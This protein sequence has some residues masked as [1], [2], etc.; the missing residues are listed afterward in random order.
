[1]SSR[2]ET[3]ILSC[4]MPLIVETMPSVRSAGFCWLLP[5]GSAL[6]P[7]DRQGLSTMCEHLLLRGS[8][9]LDSRAQAD[10]FDALGVARGTTTGT[11]VEAVSA[12]MLGSRLVDALPL[13]VDMVRRPRFD[14]EAVEPV[15]DLCIQSVESLADDPQE[16]VMLTLKEHHAAPPTNRSGLGTIEG[17]SALTREELVEGWRARARPGG[18]VLAV[19]GAVEMKDVAPALERLLGGWAGAGPGVSG[20]GAPVR[21]YHHEAD[22]TSQVHIALA[23]D[24]PAE[25]H[26]DSMPERVLQSVLSG[27]MSGRLFTEVR[28][29]RSLCY[30]VYSA[31]AGERDY[32][33][34]V[35]YA[36]TTPERAQETLDVLWT[37]LERVRAGVTREEFDRAVTGMRSRT[38]MSGE[39]TEARAMSLASDMRKLG[40]P[41][42]LGQWL[43]AIDRVSF[44]GLQAYLARRQTGSITVATIGPAALT[45]PVSP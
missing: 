29:K 20:L 25:G 2:I 39:S 17:L 43:E 5:A 3:R 33:R 44:E 24:A 10:A 7:A 34:V 42:S 4:G 35:A 45:P 31:Y 40:E 8:E 27:G 16:K 30:S 32:G 18:S 22:E 37:E 9:S 36:G 6:D 15:R 21:G 14:E 11:F 41:R 23:M 28:E 19:A 1:M 12:T 13:L 38:V 26:P